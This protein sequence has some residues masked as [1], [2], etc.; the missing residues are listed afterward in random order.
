[1]YILIVYTMIKAK[2]QKW[3]NSY[4]I[5]IPKSVIKE[6][7]I[8]EYETVI[9]DIDKKKSIEDLFGI[10]KFKEPISK[11]VKDAKKGSY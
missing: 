1:M 7:G 6:K 8:S 9:V 10:V 2:I 11:V 3:G 4:A 5:R